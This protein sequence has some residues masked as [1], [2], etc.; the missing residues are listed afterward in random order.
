[1]GKYDPEILRRLQLEQVKI[2]KD[3]IDVCEKYGLNYYIGY[4]SAI[5]ALRHKGFIPWDDDTDVCMLRDEYEAFLP[6][7]EKELGEHYKILTPEIDARYACTVTHMQ[8][9]GTK[10]VAEFAKNLKCDLCIDLDIFPLDNVSDV[11][12]KARL[13]CMEA[14]FWAKLLFLCGTPSPIIRLN[15]IKKVIASA[16]CSI[17]HYILKLLHVSP[18]FVY[19]RFKKVCTRYNHLETEYVTSFE[20]MKPLKAKIRKKDIFPGQKV[21]FENIEVM[22]AKNMDEILRSKYGD[23][24][25]IPDE[26]HRINHM[27]Y[28]IQFENEDPIYTED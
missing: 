21:P 4:G 11:P 2:L 27:P 13:Q 1:M 26:E 28:I 16:I 10:F 19:R 25:Q 22:V 12:W 9:K 24:M 18:R 7:V 8:Q 15:G 17:T 6:L 3:Y 5:G 14:F 23:Y 20:D